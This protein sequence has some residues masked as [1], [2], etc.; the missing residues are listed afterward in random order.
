MKGRY[1]LL[2][3]T[4]L[5][6]L[7][8]GE[9]FAQWQGF[10]GSGGWGMNSPFN[11]MFDPN[12]IETI[13]GVVEKIDTTSP[14]KMMSNGV[15]LDLKTDKGIIRVILGPVWYIERLDFVIELGDKLEVKG[16]P[17]MINGVQSMIAAE[18]KN[19]KDLLI[20]RDI[21]GIP[22]WSRSG[23]RNMK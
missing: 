10:K 4:I 1:K 21:H 19:G 6:T 12:K 23:G 17:V 7:F 20:L 3:I 2:I 16:S 13:Y 8:S 22:V 18:I 14:H 9:L 11:R 5:F 15:Y